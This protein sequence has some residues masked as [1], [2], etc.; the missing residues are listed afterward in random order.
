MSKL[1]WDATG[2]RL[3]EISKSILAFTEKLKM[4]EATYDKVK[5]IFKGLFAVVDI[6]RQ[7]FAALAI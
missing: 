2:E 1:I 5:R 4:G 7:F 3:A 6:G